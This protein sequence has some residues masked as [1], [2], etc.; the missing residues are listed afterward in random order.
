[1][2][3]APQKASSI[4]PQ[5][6][7]VAP[8]RSLADEAA[9]TLRQLI[10][11]EQLAP[12]MAISERDLAE[13]LGVS[14]TPLKEAFRTLEL[15]GLIEFGPTR[16]LRVADPS[17]D[18][19]VQQI[20]VLAALESL[21]GELA[22]TQATDKEIARVSD[23]CDRMTNAPE[24]VDDLVYFKW[25]MSFHRTIIVASRNEPLIATHAQYNARLWRARFI[26]S[27]KRTLRD[28]TLGQHIDIVTALRRRDGPETAR[29]M[30]RHLETAIVNIKAALE[31][32]D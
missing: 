30:R 16:R 29:Q 24:D 28:S 4:L 10:L 11:T 20:Q 32:E 5:S 18:E 22:C 31:T 26:S 9:D 13:G 2:A 23:L 15:E 19:L 27:K 12:G 14:R 6:A 21:A 3:A 7:R 1:M 8:R 17:F 25:D